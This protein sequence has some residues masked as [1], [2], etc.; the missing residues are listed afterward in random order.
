MPRRACIW[1]AAYEV[2]DNGMASVG[3][4]MAGDDRDDFGISAL[5]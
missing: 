4:D 2:A 3:G 1:T 5:G